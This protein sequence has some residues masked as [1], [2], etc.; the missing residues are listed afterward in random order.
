MKWMG[1][2]RDQPGNAN[3]LI[4]GLEDHPCLGGSLIPISF[5]GMGMGGVKSHPQAAF[6]AATRRLQPLFFGGKGDLAN[7]FLT[8]GEKDCRFLRKA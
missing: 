7:Q 8:D 6:E 1:R 3:L 5:I 2:V 4:K